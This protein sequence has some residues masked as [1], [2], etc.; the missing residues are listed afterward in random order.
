MLSLSHGWRVQSQNC[1][2]HPDGP[3]LSWPCG[4]RVSLA[5]PA[6]LLPTGRIWL[7]L[8]R[9]IGEVFLTVYHLHVRL[10]SHD[11]D[12]RVIPHSFWPSANKRAKFQVEYPVASLSIH[13]VVGCGAFLKIRR[14]P[15]LDECRGGHARAVPSC[16][17]VW[18][19][20]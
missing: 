9:S 1:P 3:D 11:M 4:D 13:S 19:S 20:P 8:D 18:E 14:L 10:G 2:S 5:T 15:L 16:I 7:H 17:G 12:A 6:P